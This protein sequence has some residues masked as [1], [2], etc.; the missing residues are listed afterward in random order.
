MKVISRIR[1]TK[2]GDVIQ[3]NYTHDF[4]MCLCRSVGIDGGLEYM[5][6]I[7]NREDYEDYSLFLFQDDYEE[8]RRN[9]Q[10]ANIGR[11]YCL[12]K[13]D[14]EV[15]FTI[16]DERNYTNIRKKILYLYELQHR[17]LDEEE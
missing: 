9:Y 8:I 12:D 16:T 7:G 13:V 17:M 3:S 4:K 15:L 6:I 5:K 2:C 11:D 14:N 1:C 10:I